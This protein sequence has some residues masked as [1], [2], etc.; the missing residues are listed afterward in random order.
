VIHTPPFELT[1]AFK[2]S[3]FSQNWYAAF[4]VFMSFKKSLSTSDFINIMQ[5]F[6]RKKFKKIYND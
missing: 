3:A 4:Q 5:L 1:L 6:E 2:E